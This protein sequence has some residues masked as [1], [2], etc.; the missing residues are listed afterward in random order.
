MLD[1]ESKRQLIRPEEPAM[2][3]RSKQWIAPRMTVIEMKR[4][5]YYDSSPHNDG[6]VPG[7]PQ[8]Y[9]GSL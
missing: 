4:T 7:W 1:P 2:N 9:T 6:W 5:L 3:E 8:S